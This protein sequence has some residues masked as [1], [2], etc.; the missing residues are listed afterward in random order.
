MADLV[1]R[2][3]TVMEYRTEDNFEQMTLTQLGQVTITVGKN[4]LGQSIEHVWNHDLVWLKWTVRTYAKSDKAQHKALR[5]FMELKVLDFE[6]AVNWGH[7][8]R[9]IKSQSSSTAARARAV[10]WRC[11]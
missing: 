5:R 4:H 8:G 1:D 11:Q 3:E 6:E 9:T 7:T 10:P 2:L